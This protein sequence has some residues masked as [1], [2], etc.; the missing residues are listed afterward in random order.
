M[1]Y[2]FA[3]AC[4]WIALIYPYDSLHAR[5]HDLRDA[6][7]NRTIVTTDGVL[8]ELLNYFS[9]YG[10]HWRSVAVQAVYAIQSDHDVEVV[11]QTEGLFAAALELYAGR[12]D[13]EYSFIDCASMCVMRSYRIGDAL[14]NDHHF[15]QEGLVA[16][17]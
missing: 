10:Q 2:V 9:E 12:P 14:T 1:P 7:R 3:D 11:P 15:T 4:Y 13:K 17:M 8:I 5:A 6:V 16:L